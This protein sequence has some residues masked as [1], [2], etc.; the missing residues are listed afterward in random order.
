MT[1]PL[2]ERLGYTAR[3]F[4]EKIPSE[5]LERVFTKFRGRSAVSDVKTGLVFATWSG[6]E[7]LDER[8]LI[9]LTR[10]EATLHFEHGQGKNVEIYGMEKCTL[11]EATLK[12]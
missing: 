2:R 10:S 8:N 9:L 3:E 7:L 4:D 11:I 5:T 12:S 1:D 6:L